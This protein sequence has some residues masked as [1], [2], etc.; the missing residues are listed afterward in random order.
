LVPAQ[1]GHGKA[2]HLHAR[3]APAPVV[4]RDKVENSPRVLAPPEQPSTSHNDNLEGCSPAPGVQQTPL[5]K[6]NHCGCPGAPQSHE[7]T[8]R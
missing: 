6:L 8:L 3:T 5:P 2:L 7:Q 4:Q 1:H